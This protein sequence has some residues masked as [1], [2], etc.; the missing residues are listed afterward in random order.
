MDLQEQLDRRHEQFLLGAGGASKTI[1]KPVETHAIFKDG[2]D[3][4]EK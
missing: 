2:K 1:T 3:D 4:F